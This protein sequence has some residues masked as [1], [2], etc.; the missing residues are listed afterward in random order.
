MEKIPTPHTNA[1]NKTLQKT[2]API[3][4]LGLR[5]FESRIEPMRP[6]TVI[7]NKIVSASLNDVSMEKRPSYA[8]PLLPSRILFL[9]E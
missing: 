8:T 4:R 6:T 2:V 1:V 9:H 3:S 5:A 7:I